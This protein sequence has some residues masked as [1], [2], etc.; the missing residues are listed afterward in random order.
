MQQPKFKP[1]IGY[2]N[3]CEE[4][5]DILRAEIRRLT[6]QQQPLTAEK[7]ADKIKKTYKNRYFI[8]SQQDVAGQT[9]A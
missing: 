7:L 6:A 9:Q 4:H 3:F 8:L 5:I 2:V 1:A